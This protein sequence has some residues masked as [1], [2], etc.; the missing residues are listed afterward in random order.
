MQYLKQST[1]SQSVLLGPFVDDT[2]GTTAETGLTIANTDIR[3]SANGGNMFAKTSGGGTHD[4][5]GH[6]TITLD[7]T[8]TATVGRLQ[9]S[10]K[11]A[12]ALA[13]W[14]EFQVLEEAVYDRDF[15]AA[16][17]GV[18]ADWTNAGRL[19]AILDAV[20][21]DTNELQGDDVPG[22]ISTLDAVVDTVKAE[23]VLILADTTL[24]VADTGELQ[25]NQGNWLTITGHATEAKQDIIDGIVDTIL[26]DTGELQ[27]NQGNWLT[28]TGFAT[29]TKQDVIDGI[30][31]TILLDTGELQTNQ[32]NWLTI[33]GHATETKQDV[34]DGIV[35]TILI[36][37]ATTIPGLISALNDIATSD[38]DTALATYDGPTNA[39]MVARTH[40]A[41]AIAKLNAAALG[42]VVGTVNTGVV[43]ST[44]TTFQ[45]SDVTEATADHFIG[46]IVVFYDSADAL[47]GQATDITD[48]ILNGA[49]GKFTFTA[50]TSAP[51]DADKFVIL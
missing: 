36:D 40:S 7:A 10:C 47:Y 9:V 44:T 8:D 26:L 14:A 34:I 37:T 38:L 23:T 18:D 20:V 50:L 1:A 43:A 51:A 49:E 15:A 17:T 16:A 6:Y 19:D 32:G 3:L 25:T 48:Y 39:E 30:V 46:R 13:V 22:L 45:S 42:I 33:T 21:A 31:D 41:A 5:E 28:V 11:V 4:E 2:D 27:T 12:G 29:E 35:D 24:I